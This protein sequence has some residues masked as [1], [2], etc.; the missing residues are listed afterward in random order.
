[1]ISGLS[2]GIIIFVARMCSQKMTEIHFSDQPTTEALVN[3]YLTEKTIYAGSII[4][5]VLGCMFAEGTV[6]MSFWDGL[7]VFV[8]GFGGIAAM[9]AFVMIK[10]LESRLYTERRTP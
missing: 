7:F 2:V 8:V 5:G 1:M 9:I 6:L 3:S 10:D 4:I